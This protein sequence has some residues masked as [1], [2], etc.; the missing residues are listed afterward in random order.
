M[1]S[2]DQAVAARV[3]EV[4]RRVFSDGGK[5]TWDGMMPRS[6]YRIDRDKS[7]ATAF[8]EI[9]SE[10]AAVQRGAERGTRIEDLQDIPTPKRI[11]V[12][13][14]LVDEQVLFGLSGKI[15]VFAARDLVR[16]IDRLSASQRGAGEDDLLHDLGQATLDWWRSVPSDATHGASLTM[17]AKVDALLRCRGE[18]LPYR[19]PR[20]PTRPASRTGEIGDRVGGSAVSDRRIP[21]RRTHVAPVPHGARTRRYRSC[22]PS[23]RRCAIGGSQDVRDATR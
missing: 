18:Y 11:A 2:D 15:G 12:I 22:P 21:D 9:Q 8:A 20:H 6:F 13:R 23:L 7:I 19:H 5:E 3:R 14:R 1:T 16:E 4:L 10:F 17:A